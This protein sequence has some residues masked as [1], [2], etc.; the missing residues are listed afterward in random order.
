MHVRWSVSAR[1]SRLTLAGMLP[2]EHAAH[3]FARFCSELRLILGIIN[4]P[5]RVAG[6]VERLIAAGVELWS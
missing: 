5:P 2:L 1:V 6:A 3:H 4:T